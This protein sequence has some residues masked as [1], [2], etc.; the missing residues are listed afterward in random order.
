M[1]RSLISSQCMRDLPNKFSRPLLSGKT[2]PELGCSGT[3]INCP[4]WCSMSC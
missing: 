2:P 1:Q 3:A 4:T